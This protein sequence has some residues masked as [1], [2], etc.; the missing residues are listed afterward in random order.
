MLNL[1]LHSIMMQYQ[2]KIL[3]L[4]SVHTEC[5]TE[6]VYTSGNVTINFIC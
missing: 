2:K 6:T 3:L 1:L 5:L 4:N